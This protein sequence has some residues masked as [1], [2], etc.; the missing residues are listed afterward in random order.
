MNGIASPRDIQLKKNKMELVV[1]C[2]LSKCSTPELDF[3][4]WEAFNIHL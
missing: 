2:V 3:Q 4:L 1:L